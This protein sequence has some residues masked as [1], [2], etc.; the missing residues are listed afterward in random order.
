MVNKDI[1]PREALE[2]LFPESFTDYQWSLLSA[3]GYE[4]ALASGART[5]KEVAQE[6]KDL[7]AAAEKA[8]SGP[9]EHAPKIGS[10][11]SLTWEQMERLVLGRILNSSEAGGLV[12]GSTSRSAGVRARRLA[13]H[14]R[15]GRQRV[16]VV[17]VSC[18][19]ALAVAAAAVLV[20]FGPVWGLW[21][22]SPLPTTTTLYT[23]TDATDSRAAGLSASTTSSLPPATIPAL[24]VPGYSAKL[25]GERHLGSHI[26]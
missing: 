17:V 6:I 2:K 26:V 3:E 16:S 5:P 7:K 10:E 25:S 11:S 13:A 12:T 1:Q 8:S 15:R 9:D 23:T 24:D 22:T 20:F 14:K 21:G 19:A 18:V 4:E